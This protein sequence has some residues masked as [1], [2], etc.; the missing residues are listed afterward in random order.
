MYPSDVSRGT[1]VKK[2]SLTFFNKKSCGKILLFNINF[3]SLWQEK[4]GAPNNLNVKKINIHFLKK[5]RK[6]FVS[7]IMILYLNDTTIKQE[8]LW[9]I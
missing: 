4:I 3:V 8:Q 5:A 1:F 2:N 6:L 7:L 9:Q